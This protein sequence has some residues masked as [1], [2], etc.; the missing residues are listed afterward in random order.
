MKKMAFFEDAHATYD[1]DLDNFEEKYPNPFPEKMARAVAFLEKHGL[2]PNIERAQRLQESS[3]STLQNELLTVFSFE[4]SEQQMQEL[5]AFLYQL[6][7]EQ[8]KAAKSE[9]VE[10]MAI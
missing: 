2:P 6:F 9:K 7:G 10:E 5:K 8:L 3:V 4:P 1:P